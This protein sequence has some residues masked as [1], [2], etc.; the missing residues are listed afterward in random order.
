MAAVEV[1]SMAAP[2]KSSPPPIRDSRGENRRGRRRRGV[3][4]IRQEWRAGGLLWLA[5]PRFPS[6]LSCCFC[7]QQLSENGGQGMCSS[8]LPFCWRASPRRR[9]QPSG[10][11]TPLSWA[12]RQNERVVRA[13]TVGLGCQARLLCFTANGPFDHVVVELFPSLRSSA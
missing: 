10:M 1:V 5:S 7:P 4:S 9:R 11:G 8:P 13:L 2:L 3:D 6:P 12:Q